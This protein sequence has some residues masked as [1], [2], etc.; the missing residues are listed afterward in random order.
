MKIM[1]LLH[2]GPLDGDERWI[3]ET[4]VIPVVVE[5]PELFDP[6]API[7]ATGP[8]PKIGYYVRGSRWSKASPYRYRFDWETG[9]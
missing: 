7:G 3:D 9:Q 4:D 1:A 2:G 5:E 6:S 8:A